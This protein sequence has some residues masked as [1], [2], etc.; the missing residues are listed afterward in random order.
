LTPD[1]RFFL[2]IQNRRAWK[3]QEKQRLISFLFLVIFLNIIF[4]YTLIKYSTY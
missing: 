3:T 2:E 1:F 4:S